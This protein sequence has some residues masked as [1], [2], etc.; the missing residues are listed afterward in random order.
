MKALAKH[1]SSMNRRLREL[2]SGLR[3]GSRKNDSRLLP[4]IMP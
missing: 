3:T 4:M 2:S 1:G